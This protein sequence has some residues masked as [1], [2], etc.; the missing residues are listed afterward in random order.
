VGEN[1][2]LASLGIGGL[3]G[4]HFYVEFFDSE[5]NPDEY[6][7]NV[8][9]F[10]ENS[11]I[12]SVAAKA[13]FIDFKAAYITAG[14]KNTS[15][16]VGNIKLVA[17]YKDGDKDIICKIPYVA[18][19]TLNPIFPYSEHFSGTVPVRLTMNSIEFLKHANPS[20]FKSDFEYE[21]PTNLEELKPKTK[22]HSFLSM[23]RA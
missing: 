2:D 9:K 3:T 21:M 17:E 8:A 22:P 6:N 19:V 5:G 12:P 1:K 15:K 20:Y 14:I 4:G 7:E 16:V 23:F 10:E 11:V 13:L 18:V